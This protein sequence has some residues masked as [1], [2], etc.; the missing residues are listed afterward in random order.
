MS[1]LFLEILRI[2]AYASVL[3]ILVLVAR[4][5]IGKKS[6]LA[7][8]LLWGMFMLRL[9]VPLQMESPLSAMNLVNYAG[10]LAAQEYMPGNVPE[11]VD[12]GPEQNMVNPPDKPVY[13]TPNPDAANEAASEMLPDSGE[14]AI[15]VKREPPVDGWQIASYVWLS[16]LILILGAVVAANLRFAGMLRKKQRYTDPDFLS[17]LESCKMELNIS[18]R[19]NAVRVDEVE[20]AAVCGIFRPRLLINLP[21]FEY[22]DGEEKRHILLHELSHIKRMDTLVS[23]A[24]LLLQAVY[25][26]NPLVWIAFSLMQRDMETF[27]DAAVLKKLEDGSHIRYAA[28]LIKLAESSGKRRMRFVMAVSDRPSGMKRRILMVLKYKKQKAIVKLIAVALAVFVGLTGCT[29]AVD[30]AAANMSAGIPD[31]QSASAQTTAASPAPDTAAGPNGSQQPDAD[32]MKDK[33]NILFLGIDR[34]KPGG[35]ASRIRTDTMILIACDLKNRKA[36][37]I[38]IPRDCYVHLGPAFSGMGKIGAAFGNGGGEDGNGYKNAMETVSHVLGVPVQYYVGFDISAAEKIVDMMGGI[39]YDVELDV[40]NASGKTTIRKGKQKLNGTQALDYCR[41]RMDSDDFTRMG[42]QQKMLI[43][44]MKQMKAK[45]LAKSLPDTYKAVEKDMRTNLSFE[46]ICALAAYASALDYS[47]TK[48]YT[49]PAVSL[50]PIDGAAYIGIDQPKMKQMLK[51]IY[52]IDVTVDEADDGNNIKALAEGKTP[53]VSSDSGEAPSDTPSVTQNIITEYSITEKTDSAGRYYNIVKALKAL[54]GQVIKPGETLSFNRIVGDRTE[55][56]GWKH[57][58]GIVDGQYTD[59]IGG[60][61]CVASSMLYIAALQSELTVTDRTHHAWPAVDFPGGLDAT[62]TTGTPDLKIKNEKTAPVTI[63][64]VI[65]GEKNGEIALSLKICG[66]PLADGMQIAAISK[67]TGQTKD[68][69]V[70]QC[71]L[72]YL[73]NGKVVKTVFS[74]EDKYKAPPE[75]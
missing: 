30:V 75:K 28:T 65:G 19:V 8:M 34:T 44:I 2:S 47:E 11:A 31:A 42:R 29:A 22:L 48:S 10:P 55:S 53:P 24:A 27:S 37:I 21:T 57:V 6:G 58:K 5:I 40:K 38:S 61:V 36:N 64:A 63:Q 49:L 18:R 43:E 20:T 23:F 35:D 25:W 1:G 33:V 41:M 45:D 62:V 51:E 66:E 32:S 59:Q 52:G 68:G 74:H 69:S 14:T 72:N 71:Y 46:Q 54:D 13:D 26:F 73:Q 56:N 3:G 12:P 16:G 9:A 15:P 39:E 67:K 70:Y 50:P 4:W 60:G 17:L 7:M